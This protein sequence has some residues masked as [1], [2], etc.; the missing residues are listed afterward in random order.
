MGCL[1]LGFANQ[2]LCGHCNGVYESMEHVIA[3]NN[4]CGNLVNILNKC[5]DKCCEN[6][7]H[8]C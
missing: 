5:T 1:L 7:I 8:N 6:F 4:I 3:V 2:N